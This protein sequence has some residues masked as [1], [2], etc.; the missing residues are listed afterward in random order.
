MRARHAESLLLED[1]AAAYGLTVFQLIGAFKR[2]MG[3]TPHVALT[4]IRLNAACRLLRHGAPI[5][6]VAT[7]TGFADQSA[8]TKN[9]KR[10]YGMTPL[11][12]AKA[13]GGP[14][15]SSR[16]LGC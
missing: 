10:A 9:F 3:T 15:V 4:H 12:Y 1:L 13:A 2:T 14:G 6:G 8:L 11:Q 16:A 7:A 5:A